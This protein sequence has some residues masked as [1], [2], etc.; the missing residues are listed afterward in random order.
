MNNKIE[1][2]NN[3]QIITKD[4]TKYIK[5]KKNNTI[6]KIYTYLHH[7]NFNSY[8]PPI[9]KDNNYDF[10]HYIE[11]DKYNQEEKS[12]ILINLMSELH[13]K[14]TTY[15]KLSNEIIEKIYI[16][17]KNELISLRNYYYEIQ[18][19]Y[20]TKEFPSPEEQ[21]LLNNISNIYK[22]INYSEYKINTWYEKIKQTDKIRYVQL[23]NNLSLNH[24]LIKQKNYLISWDNSKKDL[25]IYDF[26]NFYKNEFNNLNMKN[27]FSLYQRKYKYT[28]EEQLLF[29]SLISIPPK[30]TFKKTHLINTIETR[31][32]LNY[33]ERTSEFLSKNNE[34]NQKNN[35]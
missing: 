31:K 22:A 11:E 21:L 2:K 28:E 9:K 6:E 20:E 8:L 13:N 30:I 15:H 35:K 12:N 23:H 24:L 34:K 18:D 32:H 14:T 7:Q 27:L 10:Y 16:S 5:K 33:V 19:Y 3:V 1:Y 29:E 17:T 25:P 4:N 26:I